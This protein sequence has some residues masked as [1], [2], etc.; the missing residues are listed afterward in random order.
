MWSSCYENVHYDIYL[1]ILFKFFLF[2]D[3]CSSASPEH[4]SGELIDIESW[5]GK[6]F[7]LLHK[8]TH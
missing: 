3:G 1:M 8:I 2:T 7:R 4:E 6:S 5:D